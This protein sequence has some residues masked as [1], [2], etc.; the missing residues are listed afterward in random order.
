VQIRS[1]T[2]LDAGVGDTDIS[3]K[4]VSIVR[5]DSGAHIETMKY[6]IWLFEGTKV[7]S[8]NG[9]NSAENCGD[10]PKSIYRF[11]RGGEQNFLSGS[12]VEPMVEYTFVLQRCLFVSR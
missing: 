6:F 3:L 12:L 4:Q 2:G 5:F 1:A 8:V 9:V 7:P 11:Y 10:S